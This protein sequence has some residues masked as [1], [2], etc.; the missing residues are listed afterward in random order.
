MATM[1]EDVAATRED[2]AEMKS[3]VRYLVE[4]LREV[5]GEQEQHDARL[6]VLEKR[7]V[8]TMAYVAGLSTAGGFFGG[9]T[10]VAL[11][12]KILALLGVLAVLMMAG[13]AAEGPNGADAF[14]HDN[15]KPVPV[16]L[17]E[18]MRPSCI[19]AHL[20]ARE[21]WKEKCLVDYLRPRIVSDKWEGWYGSDGPRG[22]ISARDATI[23]PP[24]L[25]VAQQKQLN[26]RMLSCRIKMST[27]FREDETCTTSVAAHELGHCLGLEHTYEADEWDHLMFW[28]GNGG[29]E[30]TEDECAWVTQ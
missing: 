6:D 4:A 27:E 26:Q 15:L 23:P 11:K 30:I 18:D 17:H 19:D 2:V 28:V 3:D 25:G 20:A 21:L 24:A 14:W 8:R 7:H 5:R 10:L 22:T 1:R 16:Y 12:D 9:G 29:L 13:C